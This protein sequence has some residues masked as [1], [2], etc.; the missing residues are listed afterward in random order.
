MTCNQLI[1]NSYVTQISISKAKI[2]HNK[3]GNLC[4][5]EFIRPQAGNKSRKGF[6]G[7]TFGASSAFKFLPKSTHSLSYIEI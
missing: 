5:G 7:I 2:N 6:P 4:E 3:K 1:G